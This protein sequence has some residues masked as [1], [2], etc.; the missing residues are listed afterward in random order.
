MPDV[1]GI[2]VGIFADPAYPP[3]RSSIF[4]PHKHP[5]VSIPPGIPQN[6]GHNAAFLAAARE[7]LARRTEAGAP[8]KPET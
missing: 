8:R 2:P 1:I 3:P 5:W 6:E 7:A 4:V